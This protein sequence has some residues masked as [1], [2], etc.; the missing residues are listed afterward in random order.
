MTARKQFV[1]AV[2]ISLCACTA[3]EAPAPAQAER[4]HI[5]SLTAMAVVH[6]DWQ[7]APGG[8]GHNIGSILVDRDSVPVFWA[9]NAISASGDGTQHAEVRA[10]QVFLNCPAIGAYADGYTLYSTLEPC[11]MCTG[12][13]ALARVSRVVYV[14]ADPAYGNVHD[15]LAEIEYPI[16]FEAYSPA[17]MRQK[18]LLDAGFE[19]FKRENPE[20]SIIEYLLSAAAKNIFASAEMDLNRYQPHY[21]ENLRVLES[22]RAFLEQVPKTGGDDRLAQYCPQK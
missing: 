14:Q 1:L 21:E 13:L 11:A 22:A 8:R 5:L 16:L 3:R 6:R 12:M 10:I 9:R 15:A 20:A 18:Q 19:S 17:G 4:D 2:W 7:Q